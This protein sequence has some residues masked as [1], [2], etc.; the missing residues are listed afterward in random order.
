[1]FLE[2]LGIVKPGKAGKYIMSGATDLGG[3]L[4]VNTSGGKLCGNPLIIS[5]LA[6]VAECVLQLRGEA[7]ERQVD[8]AKTALAHGAAGPASQYHCVMILSN[9]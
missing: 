4:P 1:M 9:K 2:G 5:G 3:E 8:K 6:R 7:G